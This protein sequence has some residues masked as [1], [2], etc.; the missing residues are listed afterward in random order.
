MQ[1]SQSKTLAPNLPPEDNKLWTAAQ[2][3]EAVFL[4]EMLKQ[5]GFGDPLD[6]FGGGIGEEQFSSLMVDHQA[7]A[8]AEKGSLGLAEQ[9]FKA[10]SELNNDQK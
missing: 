1:V 9:I 4:A 2:S 6:G 8:L 5:S 3:L 10:M 7:Q